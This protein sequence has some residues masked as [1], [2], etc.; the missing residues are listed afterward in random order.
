MN[1]T[2]RLYV[3]LTEEEKS[4]L[5]KIAKEENKTI[6]ELIVNCIKSLK[7]ENK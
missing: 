4:F 1:K 3:R 7:E 5:R 2:T 6:S